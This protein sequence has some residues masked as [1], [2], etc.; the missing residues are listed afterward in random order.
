MTLI[1]LFQKILPYVK[2]YKWLV[3]LAL[4]LTFIGALTAQVNAYVLQ[5]TVNSITELLEQH[6]A[7]KDGL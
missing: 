3:V 7:L 1:Q 4:G 2:P 5:Y 6:K